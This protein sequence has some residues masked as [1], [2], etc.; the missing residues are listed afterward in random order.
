MFSRADPSSVMFLSKPENIVFVS[1]VCH[2]RSDRICASARKRKDLKTVRHP[3]AHRPGSQ[4]LSAAQHRHH[5]HTHTAS[6]TALLVS[7]I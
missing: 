2:A 5:I 4:Q 1:C 7:H 3:A 6:H